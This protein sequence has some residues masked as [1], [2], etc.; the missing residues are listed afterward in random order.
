[1]NCIFSRLSSLVCLN[2][3]YSISNAYFAQLGRGQ[4][5]N[6]HDRPNFNGSPAP[7]RDPPGDPDRFIEVL[8]V[9]QEVSSELL[10][11]FRERAVRYQTLVI[12]NPDAGRRGGRVERSGAQI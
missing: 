8:G 3:G 2:P 11:S 12:A 1:M 9:D 4:A 10:A 7:R 5:G 6:F